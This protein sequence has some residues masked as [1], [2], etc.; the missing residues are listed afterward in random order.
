M[1]CAHELIN[2]H[3]DLWQHIFHNVSLKLDDNTLLI[4]DSALRKGKCLVAAA[5]FLFYVFRILTFF[6]FA[7]IFF[8]E[9]GV[10]ISFYMIFHWTL[11]S[12]YNVNRFFR[13][14]TLR[15]ENHFENSN[16]RCDVNEYPY[17]RAT[18]DMTATIDNISFMQ[19]FDRF[20]PLLLAFHWWTKVNLTATQCWTV[21]F[22]P[23]EKQCWT[24]PNFNRFYP[25]CIQCYGVLSI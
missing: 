2:P 23:K 6:P 10:A 15:G 5:C 20:W 24:T 16:I 1:R 12:I 13:H 11:V 21:Q 9:R 7:F 18:N 25:K 22:V 14:W 19:L 8:G 4:I 3:I 17:G